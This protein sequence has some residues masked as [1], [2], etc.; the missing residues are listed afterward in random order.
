MLTLASLVFS[1]RCFWSF[2]AVLPYLS[3]CICHLPKRH[4]MSIHVWS[5][6]VFVFIIVCVWH[7]YPLA[8]AFFY[9]AE[10]KPK[11]RALWRSFE[12]CCWFDYGESIC[13]ESFNPPG[14]LISVF[15]TASSFHS[16]VSSY[17][18]ASSFPRTFSSTFCLSGTCWVFILAF[19]WFL[20]SS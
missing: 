9:S 5:S 10:N 4:M 3:L 6:S 8:F 18:T 12:G 7:L 1:W 17:T 20:F 11:K 2:F 19:H 15:H 13:Y 14:P 16:F